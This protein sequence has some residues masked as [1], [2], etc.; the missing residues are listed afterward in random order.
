MTPV[1]AT[2]P[3]DHLALFKRAIADLRTEG[4]AP[5]VFVWVPGRIEFL[6]KHTDYAGG[7]S[8]VCAVD[9]GFALAAAPR[10][11]RRLAVR[12]ALRDEAVEV[13]VEANAAPPP[14]GD[15][16]VYPATVA[17]RF[18]RNFPGALGADVAF[19]SNLPIAAGMSSSSALVTG[20]FLALSAVN[21]LEDRPAYRAAIAGPEALAGYLGTVENGA[22]FP[23]LPGD[24][25][26]GTFGGSEDHTAMLCGR[27]G[28]LVQHSYAPV[29]FERAVAL[30]PG[31]VF[32][33]GNSGVVAEKTGA[34]LERY[35]ALS[36]RATALLHLWRATTGRADPTLA[37]ALTSSPDAAG[38]LRDA[39]AGLAGGAAAVGFGARAGSGGG[40]GVGSPAALSARLEQFLLESEELVPAAGDALLRGDLA[41]LG[42]VVRRSQA[43]AERLL[44]NQV[45]ETEW[46]ARDAAEG[47]AA[48]ASAFG[49]GF[50]GSVWALVSAAGA[51]DFLD[52]WRRRYLEAFPRRAAG[53][54]F[55]LTRA[56]GPAWTRHD[57]PV[58]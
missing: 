23:G 31:Y 35:N 42:P 34:A 6:G 16:A 7:R 58:P 10:A 50:G 46:L 44:A 43:A 33:V 19:A 49:A 37:A 1:P 45:P 14:A 30:P 2:V 20:T 25:G 11:D 40:G 36:R 8:L 32:A 51:A 38:L 15:W 52:G 4:V 13:L 57:A 47:G 24:R 55:F 54:D 39:I 41:A 29:R 17:R 56:A 27:E 53:A 18:A 22:D 21:R 26:V 5:T 12:D 3:A 28:A 9:R 48:A